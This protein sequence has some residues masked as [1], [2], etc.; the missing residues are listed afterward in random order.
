MLIVLP[1]A[2]F[3]PNPM[4]S[5]AFFGRVSK[6][7]IMSKELIIKTLNEFRKNY[8][9]IQEIDH[10]EYI[11]S[12]F[13]GCYTETPK[14][15][16][17]KCFNDFVISHNKICKDEIER[18]KNIKAKNVDEFS[19][20]AEHIKCIEQMFIILKKEH[21][22]AY[23]LRPDNNIV[24]HKC[25]DFSNVAD[26]LSRLHSKYCFDLYPKICNKHIEQLEK[27]AF[28]FLTGI[29]EKKLLSQEKTKIH[30]S[31]VQTLL[32]QLT[33]E[34]NAVSQGSR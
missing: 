14:N 33:N 12:H 23:S 21:S 7:K 5:A 31:K 28:L 3:L 29:S 18:L 6:L 4:L 19:K 11:K 25:G 15:E 10:Y 16:V 13:L 8:Q 22:G 20:Y 32:T 9:L 2:H 27:K 26:E 1:S 30:L 24:R 34:F 17:E